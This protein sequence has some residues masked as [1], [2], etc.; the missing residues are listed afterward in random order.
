MSNIKSEQIRSD[1]NLAID[2]DQHLSPREMR[3]LLENLLGKENCTIEEY[4]NQKL[5]CYTHN[6]I[7]EVLLLAAVTYM[8]GNGQHPIFKKRMQLKKWYKDVVN[9]YKAEKNTNIRFI[10]VYYYEGNKIF[11][12]ALKDTY[13]RKKMN[14]SAVHIYTNDLFQAMKEGYFIREDYLK[15]K[16]ATIRCTKFKS[17]LDGT[18]N[19]SDNGLLKVFQD[20][21]S[22][23]EFG[24]WLKA[25]TA[26][27]EMHNA[28]W[29]KWKETE[30]P[31]WFLEYRFDAFLRNNN[32]QNKVLY[33]GSS[34]KSIGELDFDL[35]FDSDNFYGDLK[36]SDINKKV[37]PGND[38]SNLLECINK[39]DKFWYVIYEHNTVKDSE[40]NNYEATRFRTNYIR[41]HNEWPANKEWDELSYFKRMK[42]SVQF[43]RMYIIELNRINYRFVL[44]DFNQ[45]HQPSGDSRNPKFMITKNNI[46]NFVIFK[47]DFEY[48]DTYYNAAETNEE[49]KYE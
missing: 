42:N 32:L 44:S 1:L 10:G 37:A 40:K 38:Q 24:K 31:G 30:W 11:V 23:F 12:E 35:S 25:S 14:S 45:G 26:I 46:D 6:G 39:Y 18:L 36:A 4:G 34:H 48:N 49:Y 33:I 3:V 41:N 2:D 47:E 17:Y 22:N 43:I 16:I 7:K 13:L 21:N 28:G 5:L 15:N 20:F 29:S 8:G 27:P 19:L 9:K